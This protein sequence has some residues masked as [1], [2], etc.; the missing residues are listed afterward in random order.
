MPDIIVGTRGTGNIEQKQRIIDMSDVIFLLQPSAAPLTVLLS[1][2]QSRPA[3]NPKFEWLEDDLQARWDEVNSTTN[4]PSTQTNI[5][6]KN[7]SYFTVQD[8]VK[9]PATGEVML[10]TAVDTE[11]NQITVIRGYGTTPAATIPAGALLVILG[12]AIREGAKAPEM[13]TTKVVAKYNYTQIFRTPFGVTGT[14]ANSEL[15]GGPDLPTQRKKKGI[16]HAVDIE[17]AF[18]FGEPKE[19]LTGEQPR[20][21]TGGVLYFVRSN[22][23]NVNG[24]LTLS[25]LEEFCKMLFQYGSDVKFL[26]CSPTVLSAISLLAGDKLRLLPREQTFGLNITRYISPHG[27][28]NI[29]KHRLLEKAYDGWAIGLDLKNLWYR[30]LQ[31]RDT[32]LKTNIQDNDE[33]AEKDEYITECGLMLTLGQTHAIMKGVTA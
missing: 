7:I 30:P 26:F 11:N 16:E 3:I 28:L 13:K 12:N 18:L 27:E 1:K 31:G 9:V 23:Y 24:S 10:V 29:I 25:K 20:R 32:I 6:V 33:D 2:L 21:T 15:Y 14:L 8:I 17:R 5:P 19:D 4:I 22:V